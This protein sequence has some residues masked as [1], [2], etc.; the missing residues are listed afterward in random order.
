MIRLLQCE[1]GEFSLIEFANRNIPEYAILSHT[2]GAS[3]EEVSFKDIMERKRHEKVGYKELG[4]KKLEFDF[5]HGLFAPA[6]TPRPI[7]DKLNAALRTAM[8]DE[9]LRKTYAE[10]GMEAF[11]DAEMTPEAAAALLKSEIPLWGEVIR[12]NNISTQ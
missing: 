12:T 2:W 10:G 8:T 3:D 7:I 4:Y 9:R 11:P 1:S 5:W 6:G